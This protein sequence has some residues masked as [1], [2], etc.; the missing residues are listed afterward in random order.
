MILCKVSDQLT[1]LKDLKA[2]IQYVYDN[3]AE[4]SARYGNMA[5]QSLS[6]IIRALIPLEDQG[7][8]D[9]FGEPMLDIYDWI[10][11][12]AKGRG[13]INIL[14][15]TALKDSSLIGIVVVKYINYKKI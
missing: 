5:P 13:M 9:F 14:H 4:Y 11:T 7:G 8:N 3:R 6:S 15:A 12:D 10:R 1:D 2:V